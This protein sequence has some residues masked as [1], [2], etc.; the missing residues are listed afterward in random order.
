MT[1]VPFCV[2]SAMVSVV[3]RRE[4]H[5]VPPSDGA[6][7]L[8]MTGSRWQCPSSKTGTAPG[9]QN[10]AAIRY[11]PHFAVMPLYV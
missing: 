11:S 10:A 7:L 3:V 8:L 6:V 4:L 2:E 1:V 5:I 9:R